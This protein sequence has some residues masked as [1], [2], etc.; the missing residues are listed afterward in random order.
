MAATAFTEAQVKRAIKGAQAAGLPIGSVEITKSGSIKI[1][2]QIDKT[3]KHDDSS[4][5]ESWED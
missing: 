2:P 4:K 5:P 1:T 3:S